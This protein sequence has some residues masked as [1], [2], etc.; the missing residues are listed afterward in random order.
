MGEALAITSMSD[1]FAKMGRN[2]A[3]IVKLKS[4]NIN[5]LLHLTL[6][7]GPG[8]REQ[9]GRLSCRLS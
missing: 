5:M 2:R 1:Q 7:C 6:A 4:L 9:Q 8:A 3:P